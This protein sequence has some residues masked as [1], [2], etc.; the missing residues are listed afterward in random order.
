MRYLTQPTRPNKT[1]AFWDWRSKKYMLVRMIAFCF[2]ATMQTT[3]NTLSTEHL[4]ISEEMMSWWGKEAR[5]SSKGG[6]V[7]PFDSSPEVFVFI[8]KG[9]TTIALAQGGPQ[10]RW[11]H[12]TPGRFIPM[13]HHWFQVWC[14]LWRSEE[15]SIC[16]KHR[17]DESIRSDE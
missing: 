16:I 11:L 4:D 14:V 12:M 13:A 5:S 10:A 1:F 15:S 6:M 9:H 17:W 2:V 3:P 7:F 8:K